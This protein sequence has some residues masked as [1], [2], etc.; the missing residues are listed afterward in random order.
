MTNLL[1]K[2]TNMTQPVY[3]KRED[4]LEEIEV[5]VVNEK[6]QIIFNEPNSLKLIEKEIDISLYDTRFYLEDYSKCS[7]DDLRIAGNVKEIITGAEGQNYSI[8]YVKD[9]V[10]VFYDQFIN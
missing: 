3:K 1:N 9:E 6:C 2:E 5:G 7:V 4:T 8:G 10:V